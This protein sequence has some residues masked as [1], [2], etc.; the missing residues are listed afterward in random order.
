MHVR[1]H[2][3]HQ[4]YY[5]TSQEDILLTEF[6]QRKLDLWYDFFTGLGTSIKLIQSA[7]ISDFINVLWSCPIFSPPCPIYQT[8]NSCISLKMSTRTVLFLTSNINSIICTISSS[9]ARNILRKQTYKLINICKHSSGLFILTI[10]MGESVHTVKP[11]C[12]GWDIDAK[13]LLD[14]YFF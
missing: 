6:S 13:I 4:Q 7:L 8:W 14:F 12:T 3:P 10:W 5:V 1:T 9:Q 2:T 11:V